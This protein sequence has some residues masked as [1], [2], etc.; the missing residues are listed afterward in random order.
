MQKINAGGS[1]EDGKAGEDESPE[2]VTYRF[3]VFYSVYSIYSVWIQLISLI[4]F[5]TTMTALS[6]LFVAFKTL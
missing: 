5:N 6:Y 1:E 2:E 4:V 3:I